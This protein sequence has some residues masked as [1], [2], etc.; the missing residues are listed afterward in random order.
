M[1]E[2]DCVE[3]LIE[4]EEYAKE[5][6]HK[7]MQGWICHNEKAFDIWWLVNFPRYGE[8]ADIATIS[9]K[10][11]DLKQ[12]N[13]MDAKVNEEIEKQFGVI[14]SPVEL[15]SYKILPVQ[16]EKKIIELDLTGCKNLTDIHQRIR[17]AFDFPKEYEANWNTFGN[18]LWSNCNAE[19]VIIKGEQSINESLF[20]F[21]EKMHEKLK[22]NK[23]YGKRFGYNFDYEII[24]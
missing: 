20:P 24:S 5:G 9:I 16:D 21:L 22:L 11:E 12:I 8:K 2:Y 17:I 19:K 23:E 1:Q 14:L 3:L 18:M 4:K 6:V 10:E 13:G 7:G 15:A